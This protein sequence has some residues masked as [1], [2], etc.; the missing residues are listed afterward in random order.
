MVSFVDA[1]DKIES[2]LLHIDENY[3]ELSFEFATLVYLS[4]KYLE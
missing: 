2:L 1:A 4:L 3:M